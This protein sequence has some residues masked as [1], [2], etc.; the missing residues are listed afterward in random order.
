MVKP[1]NDITASFVK[2]ILAYDSKTGSLIW[3]NR[4]D[5]PQHVNDRFAGKNAGGICPDTGYR[6]I[7]IRGRHYYAPRLVWLI[8]N[9]KWP[10]HELDHINGIKHDLTFNNLREATHEQNVCNRGGDPRNVTKIKGAHY[11]KGKWSSAI[12]I[13]KKL[14]YLGIFDTPQDAHKAY[15]KAA[16]KHHKDFANFNF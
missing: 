12:R 3:K 13:S 8:I 6:K 1:I 14:I 7:Y 10:Q 4:K 11:R 15:C 9:G 5:V 2:S 16:I